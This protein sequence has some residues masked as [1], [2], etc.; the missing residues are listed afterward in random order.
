[1]C[2]TPIQ[3][4]K[5]VQDEPTMKTITPEQRAREDAANHALRRSGQILHKAKR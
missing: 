5:I 1:M 2:K 4:G 3:K